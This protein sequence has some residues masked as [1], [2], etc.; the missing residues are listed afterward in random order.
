MN[1]RYWK[2]EQTKDKDQKDTTTVMD[3]EEVVVLLVQKQKC[4]HVDNNDDEWV[5][6]STATHHGVCIKALFT[7]AL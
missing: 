2:K 6:D 1:C 5:V 4:E 3:D 7:T